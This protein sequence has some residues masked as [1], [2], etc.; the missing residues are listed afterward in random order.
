MLV[1]QSSPLI[2]VFRKNDAG[3]WVLVAEA[4]VGETATLESIG[5]ALSVDAVYE[6]PLAEP[7]I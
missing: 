1:S 2:E 3:L 6:D 7:A 4:G 5:C